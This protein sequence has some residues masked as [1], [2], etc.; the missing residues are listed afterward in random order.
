MYDPIEPRIRVLVAEH[1]GVSPDDLAAEVSLVD[2]L[3]A[4]S[5]D[6]VELAL[7]VEEALGVVV[8]ETALDRLRTYGDLVEVATALVGLRDLEAWEERP[9]HVVARIWSPREA[10][11]RLER[12]VWL[13]PYCA[14]TIAED[15]LGVGAGAR[16]ELVVPA[17]ASEVDV[18]RIRDR[19]THL[20]PRGIEV[21]V[22]REAQSVPHPTAA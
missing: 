17:G 9:P 19:F 3:A 20:G 7:V 8:P 12:D 18:G 22:R 2:E 21:H 10:D 6:I 16:L 1:L 14:E 15:A 11:R 4:D 13:T 5:L